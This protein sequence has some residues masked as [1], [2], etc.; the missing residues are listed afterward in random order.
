MAVQVEK[1]VLEST[2]DCWRPFF[3]LLEAAGLRVELRS[4]EPSLCVPARAAQEADFHSI[5]R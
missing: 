3:Y 5:P 4:A 2:S 1:V